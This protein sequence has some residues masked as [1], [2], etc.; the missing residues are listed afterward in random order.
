MVE[1][2]K[3]HSLTFTISLCSSASFHPFRRTTWEAT[4]AIY[5][6]N[7]LHTEPTESNPEH[8]SVGNAITVTINTAKC[9][10]IFD[11]PNMLFLHRFRSI[12]FIYCYERKSVLYNVRIIKLGRHNN[13]KIGIHVHVFVSCLRIYII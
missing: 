8:K 6:P 12:L 2:K 5:L 7:W 13:G 4:W 1:K 9:F 11:F 10:E 3:L